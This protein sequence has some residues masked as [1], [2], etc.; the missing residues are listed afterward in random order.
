MKKTEKPQSPE[1]RLV[2]SGR[3]PE[4]NHGFVNPPVYHASTVLYPNLE[5]IRKREQRYTYGRTGTPIAESLQDAIASIEGGFGTR[6]TS[7]GLGAITVAYFAFIEAGDHI[8]VAD[9]VYRPNRVFCDK[10]LRKL[11][12]ETTFYDPLVGAAI[13]DLMR[14]NTKVVFAETPGSQTFEM[15]DLPAVAKA[16]HNRGAFVIVD[17]TWATPL[18]C[19][20][21]AQGADVSVQAATKYIVG[22]SD[23]MLGAV[24]ANEE[25]FPAL[26]RSWETLGQCAGPDDAYLG[27]RG[28]RTLDV[29]L[30]RHMEN[31]IALAEWLEQR[32]EVE[33][34]LHPALPSHPGHEVW[35][36]NF[37]GASGLFAVILKEVSEDALAAML[38]DLE[39][40]GMGY[41][42]GGYE[43][44]IVPFDPTSYRTA[45]E[46]ESSG[47]A[48]R[49]HAGLEHID[50]LKADLEAGFDRMNALT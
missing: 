29:R 40:F 36:R 46:W 14:P 45:T 3:D 47:P 20:P 38:D 34:V 33:R 10:M 48:L 21:F 49:I 44:L 2:T 28:I 16:A 22:H 50:D 12:V 19:N 43:S 15:L 42:W 11:G 4:N 17:N 5:A 7:S 23:A 37:T 24:S 31:G 32:P 13:A 35:Q 1:T 27:Q 8:L 18:F 39:L 26:Q 41:S 30:R 6:L 9:T 25:H